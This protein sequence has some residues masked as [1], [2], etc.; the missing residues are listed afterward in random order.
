MTADSTVPD[1]G[2]FSMDYQG[3]IAKLRHLL[4][5]GDVLSSRADCATYGYDASVFQGEEIVAV[6][7]PES[8]AEVV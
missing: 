2:E 1:Y 6:A 8:T 4:G 5:P 7:F 3:F